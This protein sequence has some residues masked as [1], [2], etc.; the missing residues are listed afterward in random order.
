MDNNHLKKRAAVKT[1]TLS[2][3]TNQKYTCRHIHMGF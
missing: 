1:T 3:L 2:K